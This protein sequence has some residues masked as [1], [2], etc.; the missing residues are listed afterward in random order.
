VLRS[1]PGGV[2]V[3]LH[4]DL[5]D[6]APAGVRASLATWLARAV[7]HGAH[8]TSIVRAEIARQLT[9]FE[10]LFGRAADFVDGHRH[11]HQFPGVREALVEELGARY[12][13]AVAVR[14]TCADAAHGAKGWLIAALGGRGLK[15]LL[16]ARAVPTNPDF[17]GAY[18]FSARIPYARR[19]DAWLAR[20]ADRGVVMSHPERGP[21]AD[22]TAD[23]RA[24]E[25]RFLASADWPAMLARHGVRLTPFRAA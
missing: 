10:D 12:G 4:L 20:I 11:V 24:G 17:A 6:F 16:D 19:M 5:T 18:D 21:A 14:S 13:R 8:E 23:A 25:Y 3:G 9:R 1:S 15:R 22:A 2:S 7:R